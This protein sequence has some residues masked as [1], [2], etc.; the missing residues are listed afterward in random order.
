VVTPAVATMEATPMGTTAAVAVGVA[1]A[2]VA[3][4]SN[5]RMHGEGYYASYNASYPGQ[6]HSSLVTPNTTDILV[7]VPARRLC[8]RHASS[9]SRTTIS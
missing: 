4:G 1:I 9:R 8:L 5:T 3:A 6:W 7:L 2:M